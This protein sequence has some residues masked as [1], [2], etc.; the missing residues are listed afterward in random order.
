M[1]TSYATDNRLGMKTTP[2]PIQEKEE[3]DDELGHPD[4]IYELPKSKLF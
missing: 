3:D 1:Q 2:A 4:I